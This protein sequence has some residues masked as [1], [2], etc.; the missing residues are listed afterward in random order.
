MVNTVFLILG[1][2]ALTALALPVFYILVPAA[3]KVVIRNRFRRTVEK[4]GQAYLTFDDG[5][6]PVVTP[7][8]LDL[9]NKS[10]AKATFFVMGE[11]AEAFPELVSRMLKEGHD[12]GEHSQSHYF[13]WASGPIL[14]AKDLWECA[15]VLDALHVTRKNRLFRPPYGKLN[16]VGLVYILG[17][18]RRAAFWNVDPRDCGCDSGKE[19]ASRVAPELAPGAVVLL[20]DGS[21]KFSEP[22]GVPVVVDGLKRILEHGGKVGI[23]F[24][25]L[26]ATTD[27]DIDTRQEAARQSTQCSHQS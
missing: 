15:R 19:V 7:Q 26:S 24:G 9:L 10:G 8:I 17:M 14:S 12:V 4:S 27:D 20:H 21:T 6:D 1:L 18:R 23:T 11:R 5:P 16:L 22:E 2:T 3:A 25:P 13:P